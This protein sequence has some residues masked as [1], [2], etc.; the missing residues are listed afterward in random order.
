MEAFSSSAGTVCSTL[1]VSRADYRNSSG[2]GWTKQCPCDGKSLCLQ[3]NHQV[4][5][6]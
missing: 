3:E 6:K 4:T 1:K 2:L 5:V